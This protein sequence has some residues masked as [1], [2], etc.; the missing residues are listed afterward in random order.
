MLDQAYERE[1]LRKQ[2]EQ[3]FFKRQYEKKGETAARSTAGNFYSPDREAVAKIGESVRTQEQL[4]SERAKVAWGNVENPQSNERCPAPIDKKE[5]SK[6]LGGDERQK[7]LQQQQLIQEE[8]RKQIEERKAL[9]ARERERE[10]Q[11]EEKERLRIEKDQEDIR[12]RLEMERAREEKADQADNTDEELAHENAPGSADK[13]AKRAADNDN[14]EAAESQIVKEK[15]EKQKESEQEHTTEEKKPLEEKEI[16]TENKNKQEAVIQKGEVKNDNPIVQQDNKSPDVKQ[17]S[18]IEE[19]KTLEGTDAEKSNDFYAAWNKKDLANAFAGLDFSNVEGK[20]GE[21]PKEL[22]EMNVNDTIVEEDEGKFDENGKTIKA[23]NTADK[24]DAKLI[25]PIKGIIKEVKEDNTNSMQKRA[26]KNEEKNHPET[27]EA[28]IKAKESVDMKK[29]QESAMKGPKEGKISVIKYIKP[30][31]EEESNANP[32]ERKIQP[33]KSPQEVYN[34][35]EWKTQLNRGEIRSGRSEHPKH[36]KAPL[37]SVD[38]IHSERYGN[39]EER[40]TSVVRESL[41]ELRRSGK[42]FG[43]KH[44]KRTVVKLQPKKETSRKFSKKNIIKVG[45]EKKGIQAAAKPDLRK[46]TLRFSPQEASTEPNIKTAINFHPR[47]SDVMASPLTRKNGIPYPVKKFPEAA[48]NKKIKDGVFDPYASITISPLV[49]MKKGAQMSYVNKPI[50]VLEPIRLVDLRTARLNRAR[51]NPKANILESIENLEK[52]V[53]LVVR[54]NKA[55]GMRVVKA[56]KR[57]IYN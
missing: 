27:K 16:L 23:H 25:N 47:E 42:N 38:R 51:N 11:E 57:R 39:K 44:P 52:D 48:R 21:Q 30:A 41:E 45:C 49:T 3:E 19:V 32:D 5:E 6:V 34:S 4:R 17:E 43:F 9:K 31:V 8:L 13:E 1:K 50:A 15:E 40:K 53:A 20:N 56:K 26:I 37:Q 33:M 29:S 7:K 46:T 18:K 35:T 54:A 24:G 14:K 12:R 2:K 28:E 22:A 55:P 36:R 10:R